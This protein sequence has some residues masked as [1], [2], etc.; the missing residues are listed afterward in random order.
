[1]TGPVGIV[2]AVGEAANVGVV[3]LLLFTALISINLAVINV[4]PFPALDGGRLLFI[5]I[6]AIMRKPIP[7]KIANGFNLGG[8]ALL[9]LLMFAVTY[10]DI[11]R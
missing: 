8:F 10:H 7:A 5:I 3:N 9:M 2:H 1:V 6:E 11:F 4:L